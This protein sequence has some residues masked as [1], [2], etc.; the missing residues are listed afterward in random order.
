MSMQNKKTVLVKDV[1][2][3]KDSFPIVLEK[4][5]MKEMLVAMDK[6]HLGIVCIVSREGLLKGI[7]T[8]GDIRR[9]LLKV[10]KPFSALMVDDVDNFKITNPV[11]ISPNETLI[12][13]VK[14]M[15]ENSVWD[16]PVIDDNYKL[17][18]LMGGLPFSCE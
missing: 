17:L 3:P 16:L 4:T 6:F 13:S 1:M 5:F 15:V 8:E 2:I 12:N 9:I 11:T 10:Q 7:L 18:G 14:L